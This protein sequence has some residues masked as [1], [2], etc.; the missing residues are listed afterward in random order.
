MRQLYE[1][2]INEFKDSGEPLLWERYV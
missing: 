2:A 1:D